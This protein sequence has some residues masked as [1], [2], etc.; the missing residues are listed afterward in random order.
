[1]DERALREIPQF[2]AL[3]GAK[4]LF[5]TPVLDVKRLRRFDREQESPAVAD[6]RVEYHQGHGGHAP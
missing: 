1:V 5:N 4:T 6:A 3:R 2:L